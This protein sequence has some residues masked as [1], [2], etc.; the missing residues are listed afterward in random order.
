[1]PPPPNYIRNAQVH[2]EFA[3]FHNIHTNP[4][5]DSSGASSASSARASATSRQ[6]GSNPNKLWGSTSLGSPRHRRA[7]TGG[8]VTKEP[9]AVN[10]N[11][12]TMPSQRFHTTATSSFD[13]HTPGNL[14][15]TSTTAYAERL[16]RAEMWAGMF[17]FILPA[18]G[19]FVV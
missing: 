11:T 1:M 8:G 6:G 15:T 17:V 5:D 19:C 2:D 3:R 4:N 18:W 16:A 7:S 14:T 9:L 13:A 10:V 12:I